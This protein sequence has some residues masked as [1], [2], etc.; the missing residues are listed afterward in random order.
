LQ[1]QHVKS[2]LQQFDAI[3][4][5]WFLGHVDRLHPWE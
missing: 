4:V 2:S 3:L 5:A 1:D